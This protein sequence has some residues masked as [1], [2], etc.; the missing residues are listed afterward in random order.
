MN[1]EKVDI[2][3]LELISH[4]QLPI[5]LFILNNGGYASIKATQDKFFNSNYVACN[6]QSNVTFPDLEKISKA[7]NIEYKKVINL[8]DL[9]E[10]NLNK[11]FP[12]IYEIMIDPEAVIE[13]RVMNT[14]DETGKLVS[15]SL[16]NLWPFVDSDYLNS[17]FKE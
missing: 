14:I 2:Q 16:E 9:Q 1:L 11:M 5:Q 6:K 10:V 4:Y 8:F 7:Y 13:N 12:K 15:G 3:E 17:F